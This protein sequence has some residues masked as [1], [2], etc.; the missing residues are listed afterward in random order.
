MELLPSKKT[1]Y[2]NP[3]KH[4]HK[5]P[6]KAMIFAAGLGTRLGTATKNMPKA[7]VKVG[8]FT[9]LE[10]AIE[11]LQ[12]AGFHEIIINIHHYAE[13]IIN[14]VN[15]YKGEAKLFLSDERE[16]LL[17]TGGG[18]FKASRFFKKENAF[19]VY[20]VDILC[21]IDLQK[22]MDTHLKNKSL[23]TLVVRPRE[24]SRYLLFDQK[25][26]LCG[27]THT[28]TGERIISR[29]CENP[30]KFA[31]SGIHIISPAIFKHY[32]CP[33][34]SKFSTTEMYLEL[35]KNHSIQC[36]IDEQSK[37]LDVGK[38]DT[39]KEAEENLNIYMP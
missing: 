37:W 4:N 20:N 17:D 22:L 21:T 16:K 6:M 31:F 5:L 14:F 26:N 39:L 10:I 34:N 3:K 13:Q 23:A 29:P 35:S 2:A 28:Q 8:D 24:T 32:N 9:L 36:Y 1:I 15:N 33:P 38:P 18:L 27:W 11:R 25:N 19:L 7:L 12:K 30:R